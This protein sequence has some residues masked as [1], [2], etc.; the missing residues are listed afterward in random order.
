MRQNLMWPVPAGTHSNSVL[1]RFGKEAIFQLAQ[2]LAL[3]DLYALCPLYVTFV[4]ACLPATCYTS[5]K[6]TPSAAC[7]QQ[8]F[9]HL[10]RAL[11]STRTGQLAWSIGS[12][13][14]LTRLPYHECGC[15][16]LSQRC[17]EQMQ[18]SRHNRAT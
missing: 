14:E 8:T 11:L 1:L 2:G 6:L 15:H 9:S 7:R 17:L 18:L 4:Q 16:C 3:A 10:C 12:T 13:L 5:R